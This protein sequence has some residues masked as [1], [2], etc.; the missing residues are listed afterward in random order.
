MLP[1]YDT[2]ITEYNGL[3]QIHSFALAWFLR[4]WVNESVV[5]TNR[6]ERLSKNREE[7]EEEEEENEQH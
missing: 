3:I 6:L 2:L 1:G 7:E 4:D 5:V